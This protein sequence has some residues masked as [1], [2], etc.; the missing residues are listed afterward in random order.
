MEVLAGY[1]PER[2]K[3]QREEEVAKRWEMKI[4]DNDDF[5]DKGG[6]R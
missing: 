6:V 4:D 3:D 2:A 1:T 5:D